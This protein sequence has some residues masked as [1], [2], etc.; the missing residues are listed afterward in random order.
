MLG[1]PKRND[2]AKSRFPIRAIFIPTHILFAALLFWGVFN[3]TMG[4][5]STNLYPR[6]FAY[7]YSLFFIVYIAFFILHKFDY[8][9][10][11]H[12]NIKDIDFNDV[13]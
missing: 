1:F 2:A 5:C 12:P 10:D 6:I 7:Q 9:M 11:W 3:D 4:R 13:T 8:M